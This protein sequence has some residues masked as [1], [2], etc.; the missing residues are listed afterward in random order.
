MSALAGNLPRGLHMK[1]AAITA[2]FII[3]LGASL[4]P[5]QAQASSIKYEFTGFVT[6]I[7]PR[8]GAPINPLLSANF[9]I[10]DSFKYTF[11]HNSATPDNFALNTLAG[12]YEDG[13]IAFSATIGATSFGLGTDSFL[14]IYNGNNGQDGFEIDVHNPASSLSFG[15]LMGTQQFAVVLGDPTATAFSSDAIPTA[16]Q[17]GAF[18]E[19]GWALTV[20]NGQV[21][22]TITGISVTTVPLP[23]SIVSQLT[24]L[25]LLGAVF[26]G[27]RRQSGKQGGSPRCPAYIQR[28]SSRL[29]PRSRS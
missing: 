25:I 9:F 16:L 8:G 23:P 24:G 19:R 17:L 11:L 15:L 2:S 14:S 21:Y 6:G 4:A 18:S 13:V 29:M 1:R 20:D 27:H 26:I 12:I 22:G 3:A 5:P 28:P 7:A 10:G